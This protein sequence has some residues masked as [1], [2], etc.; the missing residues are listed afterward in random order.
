MRGFKCLVPS[1]LTDN[2]FSA[3]EP[4][5]DSLL[6]SLKMSGLEK[7][8]SLIWSGPGVAGNDT[9]M[10][11]ENITL[12]CAARSI[13]ESPELPHSAALI[14]TVRVLHSLY[15]LLTFLVGS[16]LNGLLIGLIIG[17]KKLHTI[18]FGIALQVLAYDLYSSLSYFLFGFIQFCC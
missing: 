15:I 18:T 4:R 3:L 13:Q 11:L 1:N 6:K 12:S 8:A 7:N 9:G 17:Y 5:Q 16:A 14:M 2:T 10:T